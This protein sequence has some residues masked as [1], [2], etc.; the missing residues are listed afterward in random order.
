MGKLGKHPLNRACT[1]TLGSLVELQY[2]IRVEGKRWLHNSAGA[3]QEGGL[4]VSKEGLGLRM[5]AVGSHG[6]FERERNTMV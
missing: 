3:R 5:K 1:R 4:K 6:V 2:V